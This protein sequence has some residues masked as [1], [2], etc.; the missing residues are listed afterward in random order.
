M[1]FYNLQFRN[2][3]IPKIFGLLLLINIWW[4]EIMLQL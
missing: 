1:Q 3:V 4:L 2:V